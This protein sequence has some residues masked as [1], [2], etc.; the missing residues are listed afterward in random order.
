MKGELNLTISS[1]NINSFNISTLGGENNK[2]YLKIE[3]ITGKKSDVIFIVDTRMG[4]K[5]KEIEKMMQLNKNGKYKLYSNSTKESRGVAI[6]IKSSIFHEV[7]ETVKD[8]NENFL[9]IKVK[10]MGKKL[11]LGVIYGP[12]RNDIRFFREIYAALE[13]VEEKIILGGDFNTILDSRN[14]EVNIDKQG[15]GI[16]PNIEN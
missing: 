7:Y 16:I 14:G 13:N 10:I 2:T 3:G 8:I 4:K 1:V 5:V 11:A 12:N 9:I 15:G 6:A